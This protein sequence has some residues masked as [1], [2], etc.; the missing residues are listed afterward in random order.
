[1]EL[2]IIIVN[3]KSSAYLADC[4]A[5]IGAAPLRVSHEIVVVDNASNDGCEG[6][7]SRHFPAVKYL[8][9]A[10]NLGFAAANNLAFTASAGAVVCFLNPD[11]IVRETA[12]QALYDALTDIDDAGAVGA[13]L[14]N[15]DG[16]PQTSC[17]LP[18][19]TIMNQMLDFEWLRK[20]FPRARFHGG[21]SIFSDKTEPQPVEAVSGACIMMPRAVFLNAGMFSTEYFMYAEDI[22]LCR[23]VRMSG[24]KVYL[25]NAA[26]IVH[27]GGASS[28]EQKSN[29]F[30]ALLMRESNFRLL[31]KFRGHRYALF[32]RLSLCAAGLLRIGALLVFLAPAALIGNLSSIVPII[33]RWW[34]VVLWAAGGER[35]SHGSAGGGAGV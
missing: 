14:L 35:V 9:S 17:V 31:R 3:W 10:T 29:L 4:L 28:R 11:T 20:R 30:G 7:L 25:V 8:Q 6:M 16:S 23:K 34:H 22:D 12:L 26:R 2:S 15:G 13:L 32:Y 33:R 19:P 1:M 21:A 27:F 18:F 5:S 24:R